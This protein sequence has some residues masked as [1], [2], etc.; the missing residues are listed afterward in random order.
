MR[1]R[2]HFGGGGGASVIIMWLGGERVVSCGSWVWNFYEKRVFTNDLTC[3]FYRVA[4]I[5]CNTVIQCSYPSLRGA[6]VRVFTGNT[7]DGPHTDQFHG[8]L[9]T[10]LVIDVS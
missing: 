8:E 2:P 5:S 3:T 1:H 4:E 10:I 7:R 9:R 6:L